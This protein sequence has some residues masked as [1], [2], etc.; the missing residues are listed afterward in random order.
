MKKT[1]V[2]IISIIV[3]LFLITSCSSKTGFDEYM[4]SLADEPYVEERE[5][6][7]KN[8]S[9]SLRLVF[10]LVQ[11]GRVKLLVSDLTDYEVYSDE[12]PE[13]F[14]TF[15][16]GEGNIIYEKVSVSYGYTDNYVFGKGQVVAELTT[17]NKPRKM[18]NIAV[19]WAYAP[20]NVTVGSVDIN[21]PTT[22][23]TDK[24]GVAF[25]DFYADKDG[26]YDVG[27]AE[28]CYYDGDYNFQIKNKNGKNVTDKIFIHSNEW[29]SRKV[30]LEKGEYTISVDT[31]FSVAVCKVSVI[32]K[33]DDVIVKDDV[34]LPSIIGF[35]AIQNGEKK[36][37]FDAGSRD[38]INIC[39]VGSETY[40]DSVQTVDYR[41]VDSEGTVVNEGCVE[42]NGRIDVSSLEG[43]HTIIF[44]S[45][46]SCVV[47]I[48]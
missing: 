47:E 14:V 26:I 15:R 35:N 3:I 25:F 33:Y 6:E 38:F 39:A 42:E 34:T 31:V 17:R 7:L 28:G 21:R 20:E 27:V 13:F 29:I 48:N 46:G 37:V 5:F 22:V 36:A 4:I 2:F 30:F 43:R 24:N 44:S 11:P 12:E 19:S 18:K 8:N 32:E 40:Y 16:D 23:A 9:G 10:D 41:I 45:C 1:V